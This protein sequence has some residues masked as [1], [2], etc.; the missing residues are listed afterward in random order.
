MPSSTPSS[1]ALGK[2]KMSADQ[3][4]EYYAKQQRVCI[5]SDDSD[6]EPEPARTSGRPLIAPEDE[7]A[8]DLIEALNGAGV[9][10]VSVIL[11]EG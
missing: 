7:H 4:N 8:R 9:P 10:H 2:R 5:D 11:G 6:A 3:L 1:K